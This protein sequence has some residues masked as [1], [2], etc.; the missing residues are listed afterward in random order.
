MVTEFFHLHHFYVSIG[1]QEGKKTLDKVVAS[2]EV[3]VL[4][5]GD[6]RHEQL[7]KA[8]ASDFDTS[9]L[10]NPYLL[11]LGMLLIIF[12]CLFESRLM[13]EVAATCALT[14]P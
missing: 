8:L 11:G 7:T 12:Q 9:Y 1:R 6:S 10:V 3:E 5:V 13:D 14:R 2:H 4:A